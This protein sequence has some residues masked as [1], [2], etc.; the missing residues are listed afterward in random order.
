MID[1]LGKPPDCRRAENITMSLEIERKFLPSSDAW[2]LDVHDSVRLRQG[3]LNN[4]T[5]CSVRVRTSADRAWLNIKGVTIGAQRTEYEYEIPLADAQEMLD[6]LTLK[7]LVEKLR[8]LV[9]VG[10]HVWEI[11]EFEGDN[12]GLVVAEIELGHPDETFDW[13]DWIGDEV[14][15]DVR[16]Y[17]TSLSRCP[18]KDWVQR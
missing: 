5:H 16:Y 14:T 15:H 4:E 13:P 10:R 9:K 7:P 3:Y 18:F 11:D 1:R 6:T 12:A 2:R 17:N 8:H